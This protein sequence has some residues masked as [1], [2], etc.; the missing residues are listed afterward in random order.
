VQ[1]GASSIPYF[2]AAVVAAFAVWAIQETWSLD[3]VPWATSTVGPPGPAK[4]D[5]R[6][7]FSTDDYPMGALQRGEQGTVQAQLTIDRH[8][9]VSRCSIIR[10]SGYQSLDSATCRILKRRA[11]FTP[12]RDIAGKTVRDSYVTPPIAWRI[13]G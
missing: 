1:P 8:G 6:A 5:V 12:A 9:R 11:R 2:I 10:S 7:V 13:E 4:G 3:W